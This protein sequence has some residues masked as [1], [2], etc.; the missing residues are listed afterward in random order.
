MGLVLG[1]GAGPPEAGALW[2]W[3]C[4]WILGFSDFQESRKHSTCHGRKLCCALAGV[5]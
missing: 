2:A 5:L 3:S 4:S 1:S